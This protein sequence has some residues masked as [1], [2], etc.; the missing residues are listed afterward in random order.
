LGGFNNQNSKSERGNSFKTGI[1][2]KEEKEK[3]H[4]T[5]VGFEPT[6]SYDDEETHRVWY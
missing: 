4:L 5:R 6:P 1:P 3:T 2:L